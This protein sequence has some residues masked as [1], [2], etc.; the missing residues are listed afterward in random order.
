M[1]KKWHWVKIMAFLALF[2]IVIW[3]IWTWALILFSWSNTP[4]KQKLTPEQYLQLQK[5]I[6][7]QTWTTIKDSSWLVI[8]SWTIINTNTLTWET[9]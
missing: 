7:N 9:K 2:W 4:E 1:R 5:L 3:I 6:Q 8:N